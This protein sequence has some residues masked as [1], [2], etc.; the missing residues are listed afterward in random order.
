[1]STP[2]AGSSI[3]SLSTPSSSFD[4]LFRVL[5]IFPLRYLYAIGLPPWYLALGRVYRPIKAALSSNPNL[6]QPALCGVFQSTC[7]SPLGVSPD[8]DSYGNITLFVAPFQANLGLLDRA[9]PWVASS[10]ATTPGD[11]VLAW[12]DGIPFRGWPAQAIDPG[13]QAWALPCSLAVTKGITV[14]FFSSPY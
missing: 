6:G 12:T 4:S 3:A 11:H 9:G 14:V 8:G 7:P 13:F 2:C 10:Q 1:L 5:C